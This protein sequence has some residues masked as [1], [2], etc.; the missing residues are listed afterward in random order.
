MITSLMREQLLPIIACQEFHFLPTIQ[1]AVTSN[2]RYQSVF[3]YTLHSHSFFEWVWCVENSAFLNFQNT[4][5]R[6]EVGDFCLLSPGDLHTDVYIPSVTNYKALWNSYHKGIIYTHLHECTPEGE[7]T[8][9]SGIHASA[10]AITASVLS[11]LQLEL[12]VQQSNYQ[13]VCASLVQTLAFLMLRSFEEPV[14]VTWKGLTAGKMVTQINAYIEEHFHRPL[15]LTEIATTLHF[16][17]NYLAT[18][19][20]KETGK[21]I[22]QK[23]KELRITHAK[24][25][26]IETNVSVAEISKLAGYSS[27]R[28]FSRAF[29]E[30]EG[31]QPR[32]YGK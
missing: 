24:R 17:P 31:V 22:G 6:L 30:L 3:P 9:L 1:A 2:N 7:F 29:Q 8:C 4:V 32:L 25:L 11:A 26:L 18:I 15:S 14:Q 19:Y 23:L 10:P 13:A 28:Q 27:P 5:Y 21:T 16:N 20:R 12:R